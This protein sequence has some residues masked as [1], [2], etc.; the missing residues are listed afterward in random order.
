M[1]QHTFPS[2]RLKKYRNFDEAAD[3]ILSLMSQ[4]IE[5]NTLFIAK[6]DKK[7]NEIVKVLNNHYSLLEQGD[8]LPFEETFCKLSVDQGVDVLLIPDIN[9]NELTMDLDVTKN[10]GGGCFIGIPIFFE[11]GDNYG[12]ICGLDNRSFDFTEKHI[13]LFET[14]ASLLTYVLELD[15]AHKQIK[16][17]SVPVVPITKGIATIPLI[18]DINEGRVE[19]IIKTALFSCKEMSLEYLII[20]L[21]G[22]LHIDNW[23]SS[24]LLKIVKMLR[25]IGVTPILTGF[26]PEMAINA[27]EINVDL[28]NVI[29]KANLEEALSHIGFRLERVM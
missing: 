28:N 19:R 7:K 9:N 5:I 29:I 24:S 20:D 4:F 16:N 27:I 12:T 22:I 14:M 1:I 8:I 3:S 17:L 23:G 21:S 18:G 25:L 6:N 13:E 26:S 11:N 2:T 10:L 15:L